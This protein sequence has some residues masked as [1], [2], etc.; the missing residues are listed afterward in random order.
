MRQQ[1]D[2]VSKRGTA[3]FHDKV[4]SPSQSQT[5]GACHHVWDSFPSCA[6]PAEKFLPS[7]SS[8]QTLDSCSPLLLSSHPTTQPCLPLRP[9]ALLWS[10]DTHAWTPGSHTSVLLPHTHTPGEPL[11]VPP[12]QPPAAFYFLKYG[13]RGEDK[14]KQLTPTAGDKQ[15]RKNKPSGNRRT[16]APVAKGEE[17]WGP[18]REAVLWAPASRA[19]CGVVSENSF[20][21]SAQA[22]H[23]LSYVRPHRQGFIS[24]HLRTLRLR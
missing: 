15:V 17:A 4:A 13:R 7:T 12:Q 18:V 2:G 14:P 22:Q 5:P 3:A 10:V 21:P 6:S 1:T 23:Q 8:F 9:G 16:A 20:N 19:V 24:S 11:P